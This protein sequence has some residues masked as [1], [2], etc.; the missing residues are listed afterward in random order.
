MNPEEYT[1]YNITIYG[2]INDVSTNIS[3]YKCQARIEDEN[4]YS[5]TVISKTHRFKV[6]KYYYVTGIFSKDYTIDYNN[7]LIEVK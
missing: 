1:N 2:K 4:G 3:G 6:N 5:I 7:M